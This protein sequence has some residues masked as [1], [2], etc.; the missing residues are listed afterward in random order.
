MNFEE[1]N[2]QT[3]SPL[4]IEELCREEEKAANSISQLLRHP[5]SPRKLGMQLLR[6]APSLKNLLKMVKSSSSS[7][8]TPILDDS[9]G[10]SDNEETRDR[11]QE[12]TDPVIGHKADCPTSPMPNN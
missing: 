5:G 6:K 4:F 9:S 3:V 1:I 10:R 8:F 2:S 11:S 7:Y 12:W